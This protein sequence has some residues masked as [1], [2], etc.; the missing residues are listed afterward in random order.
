MVKCWWSDSQS[1]SGD[2]VQTLYFNSSLLA[3]E[4]SQILVLI[5]IALS[6][7]PYFVFIQPN[8]GKF[9]DFVRVS[10]KYGRKAQHSFFLTGHYCRPN[11]L[12]PHDK[13][14]GHCNLQLWLLC[15]LRIWPLSQHETEV[16]WLR[17]GQGFDW[18]SE[19]GEKDTYP[20]EK[21]CRRSCWPLS[22]NQEEH[23]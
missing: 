12:D 8:V 16:K 20:Q 14:H 19:P 13:S 10:L 11:K 17:T 7:Q 21:T 3:L 4:Y 1:S 18:D 2:Q 23:H 22:L 6:V 9:R 15:G 5:A